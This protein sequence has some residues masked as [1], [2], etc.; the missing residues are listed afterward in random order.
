MKELD[1]LIEI[2]PI[3]VASLLGSVT[4]DTVDFA[5]G[6]DEKRRSFRIVVSFI[7]SVFIVGFGLT[8]W[9]PGTDWKLLALAGFA[10]GFIGFRVAALLGN[11]LA[12]LNLI[13]GASNLKDAIERAETASKLKELED[14]INAQSDDQKP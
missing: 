14:K 4:K 11:S 6:K 12:A 7:T 10:T 2:L 8:S 3:I 13:P 9:A 1:F 5:Q